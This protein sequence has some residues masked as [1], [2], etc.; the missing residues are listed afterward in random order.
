[1]PA[2]WPPSVVWIDAFGV[3]IFSFT[4]VHH[5]DQWWR[6][7]DKASHLW[8]ALSALGALMVN[9]TGAAHSEGGN[10]ETAFLIEPELKRVREAV[11]R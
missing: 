2:F 6:R 7:R 9:L 4:M 8:I 5:L 11:V 3:G 10:F 1:M